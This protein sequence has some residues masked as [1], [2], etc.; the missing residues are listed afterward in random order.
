MSEKNE[1]VKNEKP[2]DIK[3]DA[4]IPLRTIVHADDQL[5]LTEIQGKSQNGAF[6]VNK[7]IESQSWETREKYMIRK[8]SYS[9]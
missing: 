5:L 9:M 8:K 1:M 6:T 4:S 3:G 7:I 2:V